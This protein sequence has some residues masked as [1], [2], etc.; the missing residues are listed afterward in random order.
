MLDRSCSPGAPRCRGKAQVTKA[1][2]VPSRLR[3]AL[4]ARAHGSVSAGSS[5]ADGG[6][7]HLSGHGS[8]AS[9]QQQQ[10]QDSKGV[11]AAISSGGVERPMASASQ[12][13]ARSSQQQ[14]SSWLTGQQQ[15][16]QQRGGAGDVSDEP[17]SSSVPPTTSGSYSHFYRQQDLRSTG[18]PPSHSASPSAPT[19]SSSSSQ[20]TV[21]GGDSKASVSDALARAQLA[22]KDAESNLESVE[23][24][25]GGRAKRASRWA[26][27]LTAVR[28]VAIVT[29]SI[30]ML[31]MSNAFGLTVQWG[32]AVLTAAGVGVWGYRKGSLS[33][34]GAIAGEHCSSVHV[35]IR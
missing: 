21:E 30:I 23:G 13:P 7:G 14:A 32:A 29:A 22:L 35:M 28:N 10:L 20:N 16:Q 15:Q 2:L 8:E 26:P 17:S 1:R 11:G 3:A 25:G 19:A 6:G 33:Q 24:L 31:L 34:S 5:A 27:V 12:A 9:A 18:A 4:Q